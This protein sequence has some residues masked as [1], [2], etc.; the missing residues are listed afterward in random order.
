MG[1]RQRHLGTLMPFGD[2][3][4][5]EPPLL[6]ASALIPACGATAP[7][8]PRV[9]YEKPLFRPRMLDA[10]IRQVTIGDYLHSRPCKPMLLSPSPDGVEHQRSTPTGSAAAA[11]PRIVAKR[12][13]PQFVRRRLRL[14]LDRYLFAA[15]SLRSFF[16]GK[17]K[18][19]LAFSHLSR[20]SRR[21][22]RPRWRAW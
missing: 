21:S 17:R 13:F 5:R 10:R 9:I 15:P 1:F 20:R 14:E 8:L 22:P 3:R 11:R 2:G 6:A 12:H 4:G 18:Q 19:T 7:V 16:V